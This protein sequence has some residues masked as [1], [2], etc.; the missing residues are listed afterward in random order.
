[1]YGQLRIPYTAQEIGIEDCS[2]GPCLPN[3][4][5]YLIITGA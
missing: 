5:N 1:M 4:E 3:D 2:D